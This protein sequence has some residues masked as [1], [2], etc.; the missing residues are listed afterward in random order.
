MLAA[1][2]SSFPSL[3]HLLLCSLHAYAL[4][5]FRSVS[6]Y[7]CVTVRPSLYQTLVHAFLIY[8]ITTHT[9]NTIAL[10]SWFS[11][12]FFLFTLHPSCLRALSMHARIPHYLCFPVPGVGH[13][14]IGQFIIS[15]LSPFPWS[16]VF[17]NCSIPPHHIIIRPFPRRS[18][19]LCSLVLEASLWHTIS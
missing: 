8:L 13:L 4:L 1:S 10:V 7:I 12:S 15:F 19:V 2:S 3:F 11:P 17:D 18:F 16:R 5:I 14:S 6:L 9:T